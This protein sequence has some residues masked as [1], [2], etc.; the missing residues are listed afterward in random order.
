MV[1]VCVEERRRIYGSEPDTH[2]PA[3]AVSGLQVAA[4][5]QPGSLTGLSA[6]SGKKSGSVFGTQS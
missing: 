1:L 3:R 5:V 2:V 6:M 4:E